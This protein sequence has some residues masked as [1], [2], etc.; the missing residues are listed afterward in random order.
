MSKLFLM[1]GVGFIRPV[2]VGVRFTCPSVSLLDC[3]AGRVE[4]ANDFGG[5]NV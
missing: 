3:Q 5:L 4:P 1:V 2:I